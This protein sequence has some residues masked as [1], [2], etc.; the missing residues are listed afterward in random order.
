[1]TTENTTASEPTP[2]DIAA[3]AQLKEQE[4]RL[5]KALQKYGNGHSAESHGDYA[6]AVLLYESAARSSG[7]HLGA[8]LKYQAADRCRMLAVAPELLEALR[9]LWDFLE[10]LGSS[11]PGFMGKLTLQDY[12]RMNDAYLKTERVLAKLP[13]PETLKCDLPS[14]V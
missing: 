8:S 6:A 10:D 11:N 9:L 1:M 14:A 2:E 4:D 5:N 7:G 12:G 13:K 3:K